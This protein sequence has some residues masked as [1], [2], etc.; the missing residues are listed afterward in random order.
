VEWDLG[1][2]GLGLLVLMS[3]GFGIIAQ[4]V[5]GRATTGWLW[6]IASTAYFVGALFTSEVWFGWATEVELQPNIDG[7]SFDEGLL[8]GLL[9]GIASVLATWVVTR[10]R[11]HHTAAH[12]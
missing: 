6:L 1:L 2:K 5:A 7:L 8:F 12:V 9:F 11:R 3:L 4:V 10:R